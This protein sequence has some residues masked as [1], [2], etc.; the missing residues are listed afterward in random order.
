MTVRSAAS[1]PRPA[2]PVSPSTPLG[3]STAST[4]AAP[5]RGRLPLAVEPGAVGGVDHEVGRRQLPA[6]SRRRRTSGR[7]TPARG[8]QRGGR[9]AVV[10]VVALA[11][12][13]VDACGRT[14]RRASRGP[15]GRPPTPARSMSTSTGS[16][17]AAS[18]AAISSGVTIGQSRT[19]CD[20]A[21]S[22]GDEWLAHS[23]TTIATATGPSWLSDR[24]QRT[25][26]RSTA[27]SRARPSRPAAARPTAR[28]RPT[29]RGTRTRRGPRPSAF[30]T[31]SRAA[32]RAASDGTGSAFGAT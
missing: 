14:C 26:P 2:S 13:H 30:I 21:V 11:G 22:S 29:R 15:A 17:A 25:T 4:G 20:R 18:M 32:N 31:A 10:A 3:M 6:G 8:E 12:D 5:T 19:A 16:G 27:S 7:A 23:A 28:P 24:C 1:T 9:P